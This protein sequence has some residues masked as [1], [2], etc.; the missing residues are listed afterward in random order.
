[1]NSTNATLSSNIRLQ[2]S[3]LLIEHFA[4]AS[5]DT[6]ECDGLATMRPEME[7]L[8]RKIIDRETD[9]RSDRRKSTPTTSRARKSVLIAGCRALRRYLLR[10]APYAI[11]GL[12]SFAVGPMLFVAADHT[13]VVRWSNAV[14]DLIG[15]Q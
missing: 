11:A 12:L 4:A 15:I 14:F 3:E 13:D 5:A 2:S 7:Q 1:M 9:P 8:R 6:A 10:A